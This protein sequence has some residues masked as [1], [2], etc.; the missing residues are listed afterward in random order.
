MLST[1]VSH[2]ICLPMS[3]YFMNLLRITFNN[4]DSLD[5]ISWFLFNRKNSA[6]SFRMSKLLNSSN[7]YHNL[8]LW[9]FD[10]V[11]SRWTFLL[12]FL[13][14]WY[15]KYLYLLKYEATFPGLKCQ[16]QLNFACLRSRR[17]GRLRR[18]KRKKS[19]KQG[20]AEG[21]FRMKN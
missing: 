1:L 3:E 11:N 12:L 15:E 19:D 10:T 8:W 5:L 14:S 18:Q 21:D 17:L 9:A 13:A 7:Y 20:K 4:P 16:A 2:Y 6:R